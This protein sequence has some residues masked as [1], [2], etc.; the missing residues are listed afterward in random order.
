MNGVPSGFKQNKGLRVVLNFQSFA[1]TYSAVFV[2]WKQDNLK[3]PKISQLFLTEH[4][5]VIF[6][7]KSFVATGIICHRRLC[8]GKSSTLIST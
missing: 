8:L 5:P 1:L 7:R 4:K 6:Q 3:R 2:T